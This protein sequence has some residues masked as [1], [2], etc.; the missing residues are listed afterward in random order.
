MGILPNGKLVDM[1]HLYSAL[2]VSWVTF[3]L[4]IDYAWFYVRKFHFRAFL[5]IL[6]ND[7]SADLSDTC[8]D[9][10]GQ[11]SQPMD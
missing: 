6:P 4:Y 2:L 8:Y 11:T 5:D 10:I 3:W 7:R 9:L 1:S